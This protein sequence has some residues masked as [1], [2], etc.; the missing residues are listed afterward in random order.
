MAKQACLDFR[1]DRLSALWSRLPEQARRAL[2]EQYARLI[3]RAAQQRHGRK[4]NKEKER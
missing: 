1:G 3:T 4:Q 2:V